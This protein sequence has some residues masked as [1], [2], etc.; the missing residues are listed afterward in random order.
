MAY[1]LYSFLYY[2]WGKFSV[3]TW[4]TSWALKQTQKL[5]TAITIRV[6]PRHSN[7]SRNTPQTLNWSSLTVGQIMA[8][9]PIQF[10]E[11]VQLSSLGIQPASISFGV[12]LTIRHTLQP[13]ETDFF[14]YRP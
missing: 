8:D 4:A 1:I 14:I 2:N 13:V 11:H 12:S 3:L 9:K 10:C 6:H 7:N 5:S